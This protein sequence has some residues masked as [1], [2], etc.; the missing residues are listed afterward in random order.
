[1]NNILH[2]AL[3]FLSPWLICPF[4]AVAQSLPTGTE[5]A[6][7]GFASVSMNG[8]MGMWGNAAGLSTVRKQQLLAGYENRYGIADGLNAIQAGFIQPLGTSTA[9]LSFYRFGDALYSQHKLSLSVGHQLGQFRGG[10]RLSQHQYSMEGAD[11]RYALLI[12]AGAIAVLS[13]QV[14]VGMHITNIS[15]ARVSR[16]TDERVPTTLSV[17]F[18]YHP[19]EHLKVLGELAYALD[20][21][22]IIKVGLAY[23]PLKFAVFRTGVNTGEETL[24]FLGLGLRHRVVHFDY[25]LETHPLLGISQHFGLAYQLKADAGK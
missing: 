17:G 16:Q 6:G 23:Q 24:L 15:R 22:P 21:S 12:D 25:A 7:V 1:M 8:S 3:L 2:I 11:T 9:A 14:D 4:L 19:D 18:N 10:L 5:A 13:K 20:Q